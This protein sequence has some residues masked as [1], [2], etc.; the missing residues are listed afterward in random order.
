MNFLDYK[1]SGLKKRIRCTQYGI[2]YFRN[3]DFKIPKV[4]LINGIKREL[5]FKNL[6]IDEFTDICI[7]DCYRLGYLR[8]KL[9][10]VSSIVDIGANQ[11]MFLCAAR[12]Y[13]PHAHITGYEPNRELED[14]LSFNA[15][16]LN[17]KVYYEA[18]MKHECMV[19]LHFTES[20]LATQAHESAK[21][22]AAGTSF[23]RMIERAGCIDILKL[24]CEGTEWELLEK[25]DLWKN[26]KSLSLE[27]H[28]WGR[29]GITI[30]YL[31][32]L[33]DD[34]NFQLIYHSILNSDQGIV[35]AINKQNLKV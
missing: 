18:I 3:S 1:I 34:L 30:K 5:Q 2:F 23:E 24:D 19:D 25:T 26:I 6:S 22:T 4:L 16:Q 17:S 29:S 31:F 11:G 8:K 7:N 21:G 15:D 33:L 32:Q 13:F 12:Q 14:T 28:L 27:Y 9:R 10:N 20:D 35:L